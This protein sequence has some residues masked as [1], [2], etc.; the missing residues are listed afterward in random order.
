MST[1]FA[2]IIN[3]VQKGKTIEIEATFKI[4]IKLVPKDN[5][6]PVSFK[7][8]FDILGHYIEMDHETMMYKLSSRIVDEDIT[9]LI[10]PSDSPSVRD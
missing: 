7:R 5:N 3:K 8:A 9:K 4:Y 2:E 10:S 1:E 6:Y